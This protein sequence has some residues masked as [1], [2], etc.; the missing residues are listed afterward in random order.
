MAFF[1]AASKLGVVHHVFISHSQRDKSVVS[2]A[3]RAFTGLRKLRP[4]LLERRIAPRPPV[5]EIVE[6]IRESK[7][8]FAFLTSN[9]LSGETRD[10]ILFELGIAH[11]SAVPIYGW[12]ARKIPKSKMP[13]LVDQ[14]TT[15]HD[16]QVGTARSRL[17]LRRDVE[18]AAREVFDSLDNMSRVVSKRTQV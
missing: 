15:Y 16:F 3:R 12:K 10:W 13:R 8:L 7:A 4:F 1:F 17:S 14:L 11:A 9:S 6:K 5:K 18:R 2:A